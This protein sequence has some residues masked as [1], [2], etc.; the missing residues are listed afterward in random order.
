MKGVFKSLLDNPQGGGGMDG[1]VMKADPLLDLFFLNCVVF[2]S[3]FLA[4]KNL[5]HV[6]FFIVIFFSMVLIF[7]T[8]KFFFHFHLCFLLG[9]YLWVFQ[10]WLLSPF[11][12]NNNN[13]KHL[14]KFIFKNTKISSLF[15]ALFSCERSFKGTWELKLMILL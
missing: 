5:K 2:F 14:R 4:P 7:E 11:I 13:N 10:L 8:N 12:C 15:L 1:P 3:F 6:F 9:N